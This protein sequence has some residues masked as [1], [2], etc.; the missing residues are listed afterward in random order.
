MHEQNKHQQSKHELQ[1]QLK[2]PNCIQE[3][4]CVKQ[5][6]INHRA[7]SIILQRKGGGGIKKVAITRITMRTL[8]LLI[9]MDLR[10]QY[11]YAIYN[12]STRHLQNHTA[13]HP[14]PLSLLLIYTHTNIYAGTTRFPKSQF[15]LQ[16][17][18]IK[19]K[20]QHK[21]KSLPAITRKRQ[22]ETS[23]AVTCD[24]FSSTRVCLSTVLYTTLQQS[25][26][27]SGLEPA[28]FEQ[29]NLPLMF[30]E[31]EGSIPC[32]G[33]TF[34]PLINYDTD[35]GGVCQGLTPVF[36]PLFQGKGPFI[37]TS[38]FTLI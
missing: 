15:R 2:K 11:N 26:V 22:H 12:N 23:E 3:R 8:N 16:V 4:K 6:I 25:V 34:S 35:F 7:F 14:P 32:W 37:C 36:S 1:K 29:E 27:G 19:Y 13:V 21:L 18:V 24:Q 9:D 30:I 38:K 20:H 5:C 17:F 31:V 28:H 10:F 33:S